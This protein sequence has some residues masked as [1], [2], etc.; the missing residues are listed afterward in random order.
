MP[1][2]SYQQTRPY[3]LGFLFAVVLI[4]FWRCW[5]IISNYIKKLVNNESEMTPTEVPIHNGDRRISST[6]SCVQV[7]LKYEDE[8]SKKCRN[9]KHDQN[10]LNTKQLVTSKSKHLKNCRTKST[11]S[12]RSLSARKQSFEDQSQRENGMNFFAGYSH[13]NSHMNSNF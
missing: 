6:P 12:H 11:K 2:N 7:V 8:V 4:I 3:T 13:M 1:E 9:N 5:S 10:H